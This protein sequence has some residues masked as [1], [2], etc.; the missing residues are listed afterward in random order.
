MGFMMS[1]AN[2]NTGFVDFM[3]RISGP[4]VQP[5]DNVMA[6]R[7]LDGGGVFEPAAAYAMGI[8]IIATLFVMLVLWAVVPRWLQ[9]RKIVIR[10]DRIVH[11]H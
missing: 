6:N 5:F 2:P 7:Q 11:Q 8:Y 10:H 1:D 3:Y 4:L 9:D